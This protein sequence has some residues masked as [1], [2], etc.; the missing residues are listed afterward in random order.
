MLKKIG[1]TLLALSGWWMLACSDPE[2]AQQK[3]WDGVMVVHDEIMPWM[4]EMNRITQDLKAKVAD[5][6]L[7]VEVA[8]QIQTAVQNLD[9]ADAAMWRWM[10]SLRNM[11]ELRATETHEAIMAYLAAEKQ[12]IEELK[13]QMQSGM[14]AGKALLASFSGDENQK[15]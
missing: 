13:M 7:S 11:D 14:D 8:S 3:A 2:A 5:P 4:G 10:N 12:S 6:S 9:A 15:Q 1:Y